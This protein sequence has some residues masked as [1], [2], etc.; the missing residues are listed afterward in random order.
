MQVLAA[1]SSTFTVILIYFIWRAYLGIAIRRRQL[2]QRVACLLWAVAAHAD[3]PGGWDE[4]DDFN[5]LTR[6]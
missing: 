5:W 3:G 2:R 4:E 1:Y 6:N